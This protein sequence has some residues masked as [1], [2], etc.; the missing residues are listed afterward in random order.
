MRLLEQ[1]VR[2][3]VLI[4]VPFLALVRAHARGGVRRAGAP[5]LDDATHHTTVCG[6]ATLRHPT[7][8]ASWWLTAALSDVDYASPGESVPA[9]YN[10]ETARW[11]TPAPWDPLFHAHAHTMKS[12]SRRHVTQTSP[13]GAGPGGVGAVRPLR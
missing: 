1:L 8:Q 2:P 7:L 12:V 9:W 5:R 10:P 6:A 11:E 3:R 13:V 4:A